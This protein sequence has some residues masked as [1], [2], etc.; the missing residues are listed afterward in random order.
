MKPEFAVFGIILVIAAQCFMLWA[1]AVN[2]HFEATVRI[3]DDRN[4]QVCTT[5]PYRFIRHPGYVAFILSTLAAP[6]ILGSWWSLVPA[7]MIAVLVVIRTALEDRTLQ[8]ELAGYTE[9]TKKTRY[10]LVPFVW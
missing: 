5:G 2:T 1:M 8:Q 4:H 6:F 9:Y 7:G 3:Q 10:R